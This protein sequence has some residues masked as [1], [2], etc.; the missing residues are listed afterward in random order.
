MDWEPPAPAPPEPKTA[1]GRLHETC[2]AAVDE[3][4][5]LSGGK[6]VFG[7][8][9]ITEANEA[10]EILGHLERIALLARGAVS[11]LVPIHERIR[12]VG[13]SRGWEFSIGECLF[14]SAHIGLVRFLETVFV[15]C[16][17]ALIAFGECDRP[18]DLSSF[19]ELPTAWQLDDAAAV[20]RLE[21][22]F[23]GRAL[24]E[25]VLRHRGKWGRLRLALQREAI[26]LRHVPRSGDVS[27]RSIAFVSVSK[28]E[29]LGSKPK[30]VS[31]SEGVVIDHRLRRVKAGVGSVE[32][33]QLTPRQLDLVLL[34]AL[35]K[36]KNEWYRTHDL[37]KLGAIGNPSEV[38]RRLPESVRGLIETGPKGRRLKLDARVINPEHLTCGQRIDWTALQVVDRPSRPPS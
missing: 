18:D 11:L 35:A 20:E 26:V 8:Q 12:R 22:Q 2:I 27:M 30:P 14:P 24:A 13:L 32:S 6:F 17:N 21:G 19:V 23:G 25:Q 1:V 28:R 37:K 36:K 31:P 34:F 9:P 38:Y 33:V 3:L 16:Y 15:R 5:D 29:S 4:I 10:R 7:D